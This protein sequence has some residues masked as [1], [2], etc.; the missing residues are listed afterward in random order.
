MRIIYEN[1]KKKVQ[2]DLNKAHQAQ[3]IAEREKSE[4]EKLEAENK[5]N[6]D[7]KKSDKKT[8]GKK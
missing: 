8:G 6:E 2:D 4:K 5:L 3:V 1:I 7:S